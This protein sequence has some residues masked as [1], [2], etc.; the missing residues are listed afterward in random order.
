MLLLPFLLMS[1]LPVPDPVSVMSFNIRYGTAQDGENAWPHRR[2]QIF[3]LIRRES[4]DLLGVQEALRFQLD[5]IHRAVPG[6]GEIGV[7][8]ADGDTAGEY[9]AILY[10]RDRFTVAD[11]GWFWL[12]DTPEVPGS[13]SW[14]NRITRICTWAIL[15]DRTSGDTL[16]FYTLHLDH[17]S[18]PSR[19]ASTT[20]VARHIA[21]RGP[22]SVIVTGDF[23]AG[24]DNS[25][26]APLRDSLGLVDTWARVHPDSAPAG[27]F[28]GF[29]GDMTGERID[30]VFSSPDLSVLDARILHDA[31]RGRYPSDHFPVAAVVRRIANSE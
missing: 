19:V 7:G 16:A 29:S 9:A 12:S 2:D 10:R 26:I 6:Y 28:N 4:P 1:L 17:E 27:T 18:Q 24:P 20:L 23:N 30:Y 14:G 25:A 5:A 8:R 15:V 22:G 13:M 21:G 3:A 31:E 11:S